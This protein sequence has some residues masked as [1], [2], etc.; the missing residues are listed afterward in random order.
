MVGGV[1]PGIFS[2]VAAAIGSLKIHNA[3]PKFCRSV[4]LVSDSD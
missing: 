1:S 3:L 4:V 2:F